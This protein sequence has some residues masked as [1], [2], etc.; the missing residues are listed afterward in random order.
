MLCLLLK[1]IQLSF[2]SYIP[3]FRTKQF[4]ELNKLI[5]TEMYL[6]IIVSFSHFIYTCLTWH[7]V[8]QI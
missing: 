1:Y 5:M 6:E 3:H 4:L 2:L 7:C 8:K